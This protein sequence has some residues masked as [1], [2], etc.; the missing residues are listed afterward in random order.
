MKREAYRAVNVKQVFIEPL[1]ADKAGLTA[2]VGIDVSKSD[3]LAVLRW[4]DSRFE[5]PWR[6]KNPEEI[7]DLI[8]RLQPWRRAGR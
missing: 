6:V 3:L 4:S 8:H 2:D 1:V 5:R 7:P